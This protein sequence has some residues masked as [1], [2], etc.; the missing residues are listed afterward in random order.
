M[1][2]Y[3]NATKSITLGIPQ[4]YSLPHYIAFRSKLQARVYFLL[5]TDVSTKK[6]SVQL[7][8]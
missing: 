8:A 1:D 2:S 5:H 6:L 3:Q 4:L 7:K